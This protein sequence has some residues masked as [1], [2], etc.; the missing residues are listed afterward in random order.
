M[1]DICASFSICIQMKGVS[2]FNDKQK[3]MKKTTTILLG[4]AMLFLAACSGA[5][6]YKKTKSG[7]V[8]KIISDGKGEMVKRGEFLKVN[9]TQK[10]RDSILGTSYGSMPT[11]APVDSVGSIYNPA[12]IFP[13]LRKGDS[14][15]VV[16][17]ADSLYKRAM[18]RPPFVKKG[19]K[20]TLTFRVV[21]ILKDQQAL[22]ADQQSLFEAQKV[23]E[24]KD[25]ENYLTQHN[26][27]AQKTAKGTFVVIDNP[28]EGPAA[29]SGK[30]VHVKYTGK[31][32]EGKPFDSNIDSAFGHTEPYVLVIGSRGAIEG[33]DDGLRLFKKGATGQ[34]YVPSML[35]YGGN[36]PPGAPFKPFENLMFDI[37]VVDVTDAPK[38]SPRMM[39]QV[40]PPAR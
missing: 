27:K 32:F 16:M 35:A 13:M 19:D 36:P 9:Y 15:V 18:Q 17:M 6:G 20:F 8:Y 25:I 2:R 26:I 12:E 11:Y 33:W 37:K 24:I 40:A 5:G 30:A 1:H 38:P 23:K 39:P 3:T 22:R 21:D 7:L 29:D 31:T 34:L 28:G 14:V 4:A 10:I